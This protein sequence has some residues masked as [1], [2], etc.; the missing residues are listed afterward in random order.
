MN[1]LENTINA[2]EDID[3]GSGEQAI[4]RQNNL[5][6]PKGSLG[7][8]EDLS[9]EIASITR[10][11]PP[12]AGRKVIFTLAADHGIVDE[13]VSAFPQEVTAQM[14]YNILAGG[15]AINVLARHAGA[16]VIVGNIGVKVSIQ[17]D[18]PDYRDIKIGD[19]TAN[20]AKGPA[21][22]R[23]EAVRAIE[24]GIALFEE[25]HQKEPIHVA[26]TGE[27]GIG[28]TTPATAI[29]SVISGIPAAQ[30]V[31]RGTGIDDKGLSRK[32]EAI[33]TAIRVN[34]PDKNDGL[35]ILQKVGGFEI[36]GLVGIILAAAK[37]KVPVLIDGFISTSA[38]LIASVLN[39]KTKQYMIA[40]HQSQEPGHQKML[41]LLGKTPLLDLDLRLGE[42]T[43]AA[44]ALQLVDASIHIV[45]QMATFAEAGIS[46]KD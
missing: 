9:I 31:G 10:T 25:E 20:M 30:V 7:K 26:G 43:G 21:M 24:A 38:A 2:I 44:L 45:N 42:G 3:S 12:A 5:T 32:A 14:V 28:N 41:E 27:M 16:E 18:H 40:A 23:E 34:Q 33:E 46:N 17:S 11:F 39:P 6:K 36:G 15:A 13:G 37:H 22:S 19:G 1:H 4:D 29:L 8:L 35:D